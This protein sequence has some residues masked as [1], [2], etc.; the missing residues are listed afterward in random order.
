MDI[1]SFLNK[2]EEQQ[3]LDAI[4]SAE[5][6]TSGEIRL[7]LESSAKKTSVDRATDVFNH[8]QMHKTA[9]RNGVLIYLAVDD[10]K[11]AIIGDKGIN[12]AVPS[13]FWNNIKDHMQAQFKAGAFTQG[14]VDGIKMAG[15]QL[16]SHFPHQGKDD[17]NE[18]SDDISIG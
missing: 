5:S 9:L 15:E 8:L 11:F 18:L 6:M 4:K 16:A 12:Q 2:E 14:I 7:H 10:K 1:R 3:I 17:K 13:G